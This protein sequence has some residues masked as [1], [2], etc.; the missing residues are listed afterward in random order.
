L[1][2]HDRKPEV[3]I[4]HL[5]YV[6]AAAEHGSFR[7]AAIAVGVRESA[8]SRRIRDLEDH[9]GAALFI[10][11]QRGVALT[12]AGRKFLTHAR[13][14]IAEIDL[15]VKE[16][17]AAGRAD[18]GVLRIGIFSSLASGFIAELLERYAEQHPGV[19]TRFTEG[20]PADHMAA[21]RHHEIDIAFLTGEPHVARCEVTR[22]W[23]ERVFVVL[24]EKHELV[25]REQIEWAD[26]RDR[27]FIVSET[28]PG[29]EIHDYIVKHLA[30]LG[31]HPS[32]EQCP[33]YNRDTLMQLVALGKGISLTSEATTGTRF[34][35][36][37]YRVLV[38]QELPF[39]AVWSQRNDNPALR[40]M[41][42]LARSLSAERFGT[43]P[44]SDDQA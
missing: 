37:A 8:V 5:R 6:I 27:H 29:P 10:R 24:P 25:A 2:R 39:C 38:T 21:V 18:K 40:R 34:R 11:Y 36:V 3:Q 42:S 12:D 28:E 19:R 33:V 16:V 30:E 7:Q 14:A 13:R 4:R 15:A 23:S 9:A 26:L 1:V 41:L 31:H 35:G 20:T 17:R 22:L 44:I 32:V 43:C